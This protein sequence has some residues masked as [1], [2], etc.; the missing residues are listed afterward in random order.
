MLEVDFSYAQRFMF[1]IQLFIALC[2]SFGIS[3]FHENS[4]VMFAGIAIGIGGFLFSALCWS[5][6]K[7]NWV[8]RVQETNAHA[9]L[10]NIHEE[11]TSAQTCI[12]EAN[13]TYLTWFGVF[14]YLRAGDDTKAVFLPKHGM[15]QQD[16]RRLCRIA[17]NIQSNHYENVEK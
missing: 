7:R 17:L 3:L 10:I 9:T 8:L 4:N 13:S 16:Y 15:S 2:I 5:S 6:L 12:L 11:R 1:G 14:T